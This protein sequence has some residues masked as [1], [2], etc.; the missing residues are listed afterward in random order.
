MVSAVCLIP[1][2]PPSVVCSVRVVDIKHTPNGM[3][4]SY[5][6]HTREGTEHPRK[7]TVKL[8]V[9]FVLGPDG[10]PTEHTLN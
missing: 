5:Q 6:C 4:S 8:N 7:W 1:V 9:F 3:E 10:K 2:L